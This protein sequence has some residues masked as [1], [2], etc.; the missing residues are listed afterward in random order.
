MTQPP[1][2]VLSVSR[3]TDIPAFYMDW[4]M[5]GIARGGFEVTN[6]YNRV[7][8]RV[9]ASRER[10]HSIVFWSKNFGPFLD[11][12]FGRELR[13][14]GYPLFFNFTV[15]SASPVLE[16]AVPDLGGRLDQMGR[17]CREF[18]PE[19]VTWRFDP[20]CRYT[21]GQGPVQDN[22]GDF[23]AIARAAGR[24]GITRCVT[25][26]ADLY[27]KIE[28]RLARI[29]RAGGAA[30]VLK[31]PDPEARVAILARMHDILAPL[32]ITLFTCCE[33][34]IPE[35]AAAAGVPVRPG[36]CVP[37]P[38][39]KELFGGNPPL[40]RD[41]GQ[42]ASRGCGCTL[43]RD[44]GSYDLHPCRHNCLYCYAGPAMDRE[45]RGGAAA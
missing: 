8:S 32:G 17:L 24:S 31:D 2:T 28:R 22:L 18:G 34:G 21:L 30:P 33:A 40:E 37:G 15:N 20:V 1:E 43:S 16:P 45:G 13:G 36:A 25:S 10:V 12:G 6:P 7:K 41:R 38:L 23:E 29:A 3:R 44:V 11:R 9:D 5:D 26:F 42:R 27:P 4:F 39:L 14:G 19:T 35:A